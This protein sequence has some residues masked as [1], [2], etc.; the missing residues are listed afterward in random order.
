MKDNKNL[1]ASLFTEEG[2]NF[3]LEKGHRFFLHDINFLYFLESGSIDLFG[4][5]YE[6]KSKKKMEEFIRKGQTFVGGELSAPLSFL[7]NY[8]QDSL[9]FPFVAQFKKYSYAILAYANSDCTFK[10][11]NFKNF[12]DKQQ[13]HPELQENLAQK[14]SFW[15]SSLSPFFYKEDEIIYSHRLKAEKTNQLK[16]HYIFNCSKSKL[17]QKNEINWIHVN[18]GRVSFFKNDTITLEKS[19]PYFPFP[20]NCYFESLE[21]TEIESHTSLEM[22]KSGEWIKGLQFFNEIIYELLTAR[23]SKKDEVEK[24]HNKTLTRVEQE[25]FDRSFKGVRNVLKKPIETSIKSERPNLIK[26]CQLYANLHQFD[27][28]FPKNLKCQGSLEENIKDIELFTKIRFRKV[29]LS[30]EWWQQNGRS[31]IGFKKENQEALILHNDESTNYSTIT[32]KSGKKEKL[33]K[34][35]VDELEDFAYQVYPAFPE[36]NMAK[37][38]NFFNFF[39]KNI[40]SDLL[41]IFFLGFFAVLI[42]LFVP[43]A[44]QKIFD[45]VIPNQ[46]TYLLFQMSSGLL[47]VAFCSFF[48]SLTRNHLVLRVENYMDNRFQ[49]AFFDYILK[50]PVNFFKKIHLNDLISRLF[51]ISSI[52]MTLS[53]ITFIAFLDGIFSFIYLAAMF[54]YSP[55]LT[56]LGVGIIGGLS[57]LGISISCR[58]IVFKDRLLGFNGNLFKR[59]LQILNGIIQ[60]RVT[61]IKKKVFTNWVNDYQQIK[62]EQYSQ[63]KNNTLID[64]ITDLMPVLGF[65]VLFLGYSL[66]LK[67]NTSSMTVGTFLAFNAAFV[68]FYLNMSKF[69]SSFFTIAETIPQAKK[70]QELLLREDKE[71]ENKSFVTNT[72]GEIRVDHITFRYKKNMPTILNNFNLKIKKGEFIGIVGKSGSGKSSL[73]RLLLGFEKA[74]YGSVYYDGRD[75]AGINH[76]SM[77]KNIGII[78]QGEELMEGT[79][80][81][82]ITLGRNYTTEQIE[83]VLKTVNFFEA[84]KN[85]PLGLSTPISHESEEFSGGET[86]KILIART[87]IEK[88]PILIFDEATSSLNKN[89]QEMVVNF[90]ENLEATRIIIAQR[91]STIKNA[92]RILFLEKGT[93]KEE[94]TY[95]ELIEK[96]GSFYNF[97]NA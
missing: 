75:L 59:T 90:I 95:E 12:K 16:E 35:K 18:K 28:Q 69:V 22:V 26:A 50:K 64:L 67:E 52:R 33:N 15:V 49:A 1:I 29:S 48:F 57:I 58:N 86:Q 81:E 76:Q 80:R 92:D 30:K 39:K 46:D 94:G 84:Y 97:L 14:L 42:Q 43:F 70:V 61:N 36:K 68:P 40:L 79:L 51:S 31:F 89:S 66:S 65:L 85:L 82:N 83:D 73:I 54:Y 7:G 27:I 62:Q 78:M 96:R 71:V 4:F 91:L 23:E 25:R 38:S 45:D 88:K 55:L 17:S 3:K 34:E 9:L 11:C 53:G 44:I 60:V 93:I 6:Q 8:S 37:F 13:S 32:P 20:E 41:L 77:R 5:K 74:E 63:E 56:F 21:E 24:A 2:E 10:K 47:L 19:T 87:I 72:S